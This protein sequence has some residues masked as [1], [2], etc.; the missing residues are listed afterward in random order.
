MIRTVHRR[1]HESIEA[2]YTFDWTL[3][4]TKGDWAQMDTEQDAAWFGQ[5]ANPFKR[6]ILQYIEGDT[7]R[8][9]CDTDEEFTS[10]LDS[11]ALYHHDNDKWKG[12]DPWSDRLTKRFA[13]V[14][15]RHLV[16]ASCF[17]EPSPEP[18][19]TP[20]NQPREAEA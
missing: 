11:I 14:G 8:I 20:E 19:T 2:A 16:H 17:R 1:A 5:W 10:E 18:N 6:T 4:S 7:T 15:A 12:I 9:D 3:C 13:A